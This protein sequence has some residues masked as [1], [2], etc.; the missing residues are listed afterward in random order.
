KLSGTTHWICTLD[1]HTGSDLHTLD[2]RTLDL[3]F[4]RTGSAH[5]ICA[6]WICALDLHTGSARSIRIPDTASLSLADRQSE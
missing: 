6:H 3:R 2:L 5:W 4:L 1:L